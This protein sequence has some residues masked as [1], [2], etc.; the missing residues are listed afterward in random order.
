MKD[1]G[2]GI[3]ATCVEEVLGSA[4]NAAQKGQSQFQTPIEFAKVISPLLP[5]TRDTIVDLT[6]GAGQLLAG[7]TVSDTSHLLAVEIQKMNN[8]K[9][10]RPAYDP[11][12]WGRITGD[13]TLVFPLLV[14]AGFRA[15]LF[16]LNPPYDVH[17]YRERLVS[18]FESDLDSVVTAFRA[19]DPNLKDTLIDSTIAIWL[20]SLD[21]MTVRGEGVLIA[22][23]A[24]MERLV[25][26]PDAPHAALSNHV[27][28]RFVMD[29]NPMTNDKKSRWQD[30]YKT[31]IIYFARAH[32][33][34]CRYTVTELAD[35]NQLSMAIGRTQ[36][37]R[38]RLGLAVM[39]SN[40]T[41]QDP[42]TV[43]VFDAVKEEWRQ[44]TR[45]DGLYRDDYNIWL[46]A[47]GCI[48]TQ[49]SRFDLLNH[50]VDRELAS[51]LHSMKG[52]RPM[53]L[54]MQVATRTAVKEAVNGTMWRVHPDLPKAVA[55]AIA[56]YDAVRAPLNPLSDAQRLGFADE[57]RWLTCKRTFENGKVMFTAGKRYELSSRTVLVERHTMKPNNE[58]GMDSILLNGQEL[59]L[60]LRGEDNREYSFF[61][62]RHMKPGINIT[63]L[64]GVEQVSPDYTL[65][66]LLEHFEMPHVPDVSEAARKLYEE[67]KLVI[68]KI[69]SFIHEHIDPHFKLKRLQREDLARAGTTNGCVFS[70][71]TGCHDRNQPILMSD[72]TTKR[73][74]DIV[75]GD[76]I[77]GLRGAADVLG[78]VR[79]R[80]RMYKVVPTKGDPFIVNEDHLLTLVQT[81]K[82]KSGRHSKHNGRVIDVS[83]KNWLTWKSRRKH[84]HKLFRVGVE[85][86]ESPVGINPYLLGVILGDGSIGTDNSV[87]ITSG[88]CEILESIKAI[89][90]EN[91]WQLRI[92][93][94][95][96]CDQIFIKECQ[97]LRDW[98]RRYR[99]LGCN[100]GNK[101][102][103]SEYKTNSR[104]VRLS[105][106]AGL[107]DTDGSL[108]G[109]GFDYIS[110]SATLAN[111]VAFIARSLG[112]AAYVRPCD[113]FCQTGNGGTYHRVS[114]SGDCSIVPVRIQRKRA[115]KRTQIKDVSRTGFNIEPAGEDDYFGFDIGGDGRF[116][117]GDFTVTHNCG[118]SIGGVVYTLL[119]VG[120][121]WAAS[122]RNR[123]LTPVKPCLF[124]APENLH[125]QLIAEWKR[126]FGMKVTVLDSQETYLKLTHDRM[127]PLSPGWYVT[128]YTQLGLNKVRHMPD[129]DKCPYDFTEVAKLMRFYGVDLSE[130]K[131]YKPLDEDLPCPE[132]QSPLI[133]A[134]IA[135]CRYRYRHFT[136]GVTE[137][138]SDHKRA[139]ALRHKTEYVPVIHDVKCI[140]YPTLADEC[141]HEFAC[142]TID[143][144]TRIKGAETLIGKAVRELDPP[145]RLVMTATAIKNRLRD[146][147]WLIWWAA[148]GKDLAT[149][150][151]PYT[152]EP[153]EQERFAAEFNV[154]ER[155]LTQEEKDRKGKPRK[156]NGKKPRGKVGVE[157]CNIH[158]LWKLIAPNI[159]RRRKEDFG[160]EIVKKVKHV[161]RAPMGRKQYEVYQYH[162]LGKYIAKTGKDAT[163]AKLTRLRQAAAAPTNPG[164]VQLPTVQ[165][166]VLG[167]M[168]RSDSDYIPKLAC[169]LDIIAQRMAVGD[170]T[171]VFSAFHEPL[172]TL[173]SRLNQAMIPHD[174]L[175]GRKS[176]A[177]RGRL[178]S[179]FSRGL[180]RAKP[181]LLGGMKAMAEGNNWPKAN[182]VILL[183][184][185]W[186]WDLYEQ[187]IN[188]VHRMNSPKDVNIWA[189]ITEGTI[190]R[191]LESMTD[192]K[193]DSSSLVIDGKLIGEATEEIN[194]SELLKIAYREF[195]EGKIRVFEESLLEAEWPALKS[196]LADSWNICRQL[197]YQ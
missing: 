89:A 144:G 94:S 5:P 125:D 121:D 16:A 129:P 137:W 167:G 116:L 164:L 165:E 70:W 139:H 22:N 179:D 185:D 161:I 45:K 85:Y 122:V 33:S 106:L 178:S 146:I 6:A 195:K 50:K 95:R 93:K 28:A 101:F 47:Q 40:Q 65:Q 96:G 77:Q 107:I 2:S 67:N 25:F 76:R 159:L 166:G 153:E 15:D 17:M 193:G 92:R 188:R 104:G 10:D 147:F 160:E 189:I 32:T 81:N 64:A 4:E 170:Q 31:E 150:R 148:G 102:V 120:V 186:A 26:G 98:L 18:L 190:E 97:S 169:A 55:R 73:A 187:A 127:T 90:N 39:F 52:R 38:Y 24:T 176:S 152:S 105:V 149:P 135:V 91:G 11:V 71:D 138:L 115:N 36:R 111:D 173:S 155:N 59:L 42:S 140:Y 123:G 20:M 30:D 196:R 86:P 151:F 143:E 112:L 194:L 100:S 157:V 37:H 60:S 82:T 132:G 109:N 9:L 118:K 191:K 75:V 1:V 12:H 130:A 124:V 61:D 183:A 113:K 117:L 133:H 80:G 51:R 181:V 87:G 108:H 114:I 74:V 197:D 172:D 62:K 162:L 43:E 34:G 3:D 49:L 66:D 192:E 99:L 13:A 136:K 145:N 56:E 88:D 126:R 83:V 68:D 156:Q 63:P 174:V 19:T 103:P 158:R 48:Q 131:A 35:V 142:V 72:G 171:V 128:S 23:H 53:D 134:A 141:G 184:F 21:R 180:P 79:G 8:A 110:K 54:V 44:R 78:L 14:S 154:C 58:G 168:Y 27:W 119:R 182:N 41:Q 69:Q 57:E 177:L 163:I 29:G 84:V 7:L 175:D 46:D